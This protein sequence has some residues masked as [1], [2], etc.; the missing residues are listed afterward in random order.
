MKLSSDDVL[1]VLTWLDRGNVETYLLVCAR[2]NTLID[3]S[4]SLLP[5]RTICCA[6]IQYNERER[7]FEVDVRLDWPEIDPA[8]WPGCKQTF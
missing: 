5:L 8:K 2:L 6:A 4:S 1:E 3:K 7:D